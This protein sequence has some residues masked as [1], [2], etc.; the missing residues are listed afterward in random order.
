MEGRERLGRNGRKG[1][2]RGQWREEI[3]DGWRESLGEIRGQTN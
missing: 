1:G 2:R 3:I